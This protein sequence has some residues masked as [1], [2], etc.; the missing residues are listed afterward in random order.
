MLWIGVAP[1]AFLKPTRAA[2]DSTLTAYRAALAQP[3]VDQVQ[4]RSTP[5]QISRQEEG[6]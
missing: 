6:R 4:L 2:L 1:E 3:D 5:E